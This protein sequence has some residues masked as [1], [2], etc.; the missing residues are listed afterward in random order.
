[1]QREI[2]G[3]DRTARVWA[4]RLKVGAA[5]LSADVCKDKQA[6][7]GSVEPKAV[8]SPLLKAVEQL[9]AAQAAASSAGPR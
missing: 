2:T 8:Q 9:I 1:M 4:A 7:A 5:R 6:G 3:S